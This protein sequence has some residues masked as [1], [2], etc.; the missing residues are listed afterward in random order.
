MRTVFDQRHGLTIADK[1]GITL[2][3]GRGHEKVIFR[4]CG[5]EIARYNVRRASKS[6]SHNYISKQLH[7]TVKEC[8][9]LFEC[10]MTKEEYV[11]RLRDKQLLPEDC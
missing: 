8:K 7:L 9:E 6:V 4:Y 3:P 5:K 1:L 2:V 10:T 11:K